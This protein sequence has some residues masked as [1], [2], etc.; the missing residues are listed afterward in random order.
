MRG[1]P[2]NVSYDS[3]ALLVNGQRVLLQSGSVHYARSTADMWPGIM[4]LSRVHG[5]NIICAYVFCQ[6]NCRQ[7]PVTALSVHC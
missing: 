1:V 7:P 4:R 2:Y 6:C 5:I 3:R